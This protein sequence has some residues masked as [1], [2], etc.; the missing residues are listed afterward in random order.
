MRCVDLVLGAALALA[1]LGA[2]AAADPNAA[3]PNAAGRALYEGHWSGDARVT[4]SAGRS[5]SAAA[6]ACVSC[7]RPSGL[8]SFEGGVVVPPIAGSFLTEAYDPATSDRL[9][10]KSTRLNSSH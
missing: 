3:D 10:R 7:H 4:S 1:G 2:V 5:L 8:G 9:D 6:G